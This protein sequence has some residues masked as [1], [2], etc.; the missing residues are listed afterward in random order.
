MFEQPLNYKHAELFVQGNGSGRAGL[1]VPKHFVLGDGFAC[2]ELKVEGI[3]RRAAGG[4]ADH[5]HP[6]PD[7]VTDLLVT[8]AFTQAEHF[9]T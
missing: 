9:S 3:P 4:L 7:S 6:D 2:A 1:N 8:S 5:R